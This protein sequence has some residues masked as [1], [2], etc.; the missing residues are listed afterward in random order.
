M[1]GHNHSRTVRAPVKVL[2]IAGFGRSGSTLVDNALNEIPGFFSVGELMYLWDRGILKGGRCGCGVALSECLFWQPLLY[3]AYGDSLALA[4]SDALAIRDRLHFRDVFF[5]QRLAS[6][7]RSDEL[8]QYA[9]H[10]SRIYAAIKA[11][12]GSDVVVDSSKFPAHGYVLQRVRNIDLHVLHLV[13]DARG[14]AH[15]RTR[16]KAYDPT[17]GRMMQTSGIVRS[18][19]LWYFWNAVTA[20]EWSN[21]A[22]YML[23]RY[24]DFIADPRAALVE[25]VRFLGENPGQLSFSEGTSIQLSG[26]HAVS[27]NPSRF[28]RGSIQ[29]RVDAEWKRGMPA[30]DKVGVTALTWPLLARLGYP[31]LS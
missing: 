30:H 14:V 24:E 18:A 8:T 17:T 16:L 26:N 15:S 3:E 29:L 9:R 22:K 10:L 7:A 31:L 12:S 25:I 21:S 11:H 19:A 2:F 13:R 4:A 6:R 5:R 27:G 23:M 20:I 1:T 28:M